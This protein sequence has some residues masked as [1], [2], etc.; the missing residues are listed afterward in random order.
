MLASRLHDFSVSAAIEGQPPEWHDRGGF[1]HPDVGKVLEVI[2]GYETKLVGWNT[3]ESITRKKP[4]V[5][6]SDDLEDKKYYG[7]EAWRTKVRE[8]L[9]HHFPKKAPPRAPIFKVAPAASS[10]TLVKDTRLLSQWSRAARAVTHIEMELGGVYR[11]AWRTNRIY[12]V[13]AIRALSDIVGYKRSGAWT[14]YACHVAAAFTHRLIR[15]GLINLK[16]TESDNS[17]TAVYIQDVEYC[18]NYLRA[19]YEAIKGLEAEHDQ[20]LV[21][22]Q[23]CNINNPEQVRLLR[24]RVGEYLGVDKLRPELHRVIM[25]LEECQKVLKTKA[26]HFPQW[27][28]TNKGRQETM[29]EF[30]ELL[31]E[32][33]GYLKRLD[34]NGMR[35]SGT[36]ARE[37]ILLE[38]YLTNG[39]LR[40]SY[41]QSEF[42][43]LVK[44]IQNARTKD[45]LLWFT[46]A[47]EQVIN[48]LIRAFR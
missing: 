42:S 44:D 43:Q 9:K 32:L 45:Q 48:K 33:M 46:G 12:P 34:Y 30:S 16:A 5:A 26:N 19:A 8:S 20:I 40:P 38:D 41:S 7:N 28:S 11:A 14:E 4:R 24:A 17:E 31:G 3:P 27:S 18:E 36:G 23:N 10:N 37:L 6:I 15:M 29:S 35:I 2:P 1:I 39:Y 13:L 21:Q 22:A 47:I 25:G